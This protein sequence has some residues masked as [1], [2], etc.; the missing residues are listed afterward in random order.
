MPLQARPSPSYQKPFT[1][2]KQY[3]PVPREDPEDSACLIGLRWTQTE[4]YAFPNAIL[5]VGEP[6]GG[7]SARE[8]GS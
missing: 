6:A 3:P 8:G 5:E 2:H 1:P 7:E 4:C